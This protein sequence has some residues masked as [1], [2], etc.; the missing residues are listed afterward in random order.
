MCSTDV[1]ASVVFRQDFVRRSRKARSCYEC[2]GPI[3]VG[4]SYIRTSMIHERGDR[5]ERCATHATCDAV[6]DF[7]REHICEVEGEHGFILMG[8]LG[9][10]IASLDDTYGMGWTEAEADEVRALGF[11]PEAGYRQV[12]E[13]VWEFARE[14]ARGAA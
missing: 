3:P 1:D 4:S 5:P 10:E 2:D 9:E 14:L 12:A 7:V 13:W 8:G 6:C 11:D